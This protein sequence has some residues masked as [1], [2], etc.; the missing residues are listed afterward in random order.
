MM[1]DIVVTAAQVAVIHPRHAEIDDFIA[2]VAITAGQ[3]LYLT[4][5]GKANLYNSNGSGTLQPLGIALDSVGAGQGVSVLKRGFV[6]GFTISG[7]AYDAAV[8]GSNTAG[9]LSDGAGA[10][11]VVLGRV[12]ATADSPSKALYVDMPWTTILS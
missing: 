10:S 3:V 5:A 2:A 6:A 11:S 8:Y 1:A 9:A 4:S 7:L 12:K